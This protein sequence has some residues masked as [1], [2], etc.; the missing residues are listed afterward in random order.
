MRQKI[1]PRR[2][3]ECSHSEQQSGAGALWNDAI[4]GTRRR[5]GSWNGAIPTATISSRLVA[6]G[7]RLF[8]RSL[9]QNRGHH[10]DGNDFRPRRCAA[11]AG[12]MQGVSANIARV[13]C[14]IP[15]AANAVCD[16]RHHR[17]RICEAAFATNSDLGTLAIPVAEFKIIDARQA[18]PGPYDPYHRTAI[19]AQNSS[20]MPCPWVPVAR[21]VLSTILFCGNRCYR[22]DGAYLSKEAPPDMKNSD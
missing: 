4:P 16:V 12:L 17:E 18:K 1:E 21:A 15:M 7:P 6:T 2:R 22:P 10:G 5:Q 20:S 3:R 14:T 11:T 8:G 9:R 13:G 19:A